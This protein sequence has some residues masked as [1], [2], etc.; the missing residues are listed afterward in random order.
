VPREH[1]AHRRDQIG[2]RRRALRGRNAPQKFRRILRANSILRDERQRAHYDHLLEIALQ[3]RGLGAKRGIFFLV[4]LFGAYLLLENVSKIPLAPAHV[5]EVFERE[6]KRSGLVVS[7]ELSDTI[8]RGGPRKKL[9]DIATPKKLENQ[10]T[11]KEATTSNATVPRESCRADL[12]GALA[13][14][15]SSANGIG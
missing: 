10:D 12:G 14:K 4:V 5:V 2:L 15:S 11:P 6:A 1:F 8:G 9:D 3:Q 13:R 7:S